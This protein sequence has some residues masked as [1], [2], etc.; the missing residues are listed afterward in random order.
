M[1]PLGRRGS[2]WSGAAPRLECPRLGDQDRPPSRALPRPRR[3]RAGAACRARGGVRIRSAGRPLPNAD[4]IRT[5]YWVAVI[6]GA[7]I[8]RR[9]PRVPDCRTGAVPGSARPL[10]PA[11]H[12]RG[13][14]LRAPR[15][16]PGGRRGRPVRVRHR[17]DDQGQGGPGHRP[18]GPG[19]R[20]R[21]RGPGQRPQHSRGIRA[22]Q[23]QRH[24]A[25]M[26]LALRVS[27]RPPGGSDLLLRRA[28]RSRGHHGPPA[29]RPPPTST[30]RWFIPTLG[31]QVDAIPG[32]DVGTWFRAD[33]VGTYHG[34][35]TSFSGS[36]YAAMRAWVH[37]VTP[38]DTSTSSI[39]SASSS[40]R[41]RT[42][43]PRGL[44]RARRRGP[45]HDAAG[46]DSGRA[47]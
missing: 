45:S 22:A 1:C 21:P 5:A 2:P 6:V 10:P 47:T 9:R 33:E 20:Q 39:R 18:G 7:A 23:H 3:R 17:D 34:Q 4:D 27:G 37:V 25:A 28:D 36:S 30:H 41:P 40:P 14:G 32:Q 35:S 13:P 31:G 43:W 38:Q 8:D 46:C 42:T 11:I 44:R 24:R 19:R 26:A 16:S 12:S 15:R 29:R